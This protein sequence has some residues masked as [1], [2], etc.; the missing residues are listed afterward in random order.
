MSVTIPLGVGHGAEPGEA[1]LSRPD[2][3]APA[4][5][6]LAAAPSTYGTP[7]YREAVRRV[8]EAWP[9]AVLM[10]TDACGFTSRADWHLR[11]PFICDG[12]DSL[13]VLCECDG[14]MS[15]ETWLELRD[16][17]DAGLPCW[18][19]TDG[20]GLTSSRSVRMRLYRSGTRSVRR[21][22]VAEVLS[23]RSTPV[24]AGALSRVISTA[25]GMTRVQPWPTGAGSPSS[26]CRTCRRCTPQR[27]A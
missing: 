19:A 13:V 11:W 9:Q 23:E 24:G 1:R 26:R 14:T 7:R 18:F 21:W 4:V 2:A 5:V 20:G 25:Q 8:T 3:I 15:Q 6:Y 17:M 16:A 27:C 10:D 12:I 22:A